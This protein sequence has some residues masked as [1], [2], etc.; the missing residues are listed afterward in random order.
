MGK[1]NPTPF[2]RREELLDDVC[3]CGETVNDIAIRASPI[4]ASLSRDL[5]SRLKN[6]SY[7]SAPSMSIRSTRITR[8]F[9]T[10]AT[11]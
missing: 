7:R 3:K 11:A 9:R 6:R 8:G 5:L 2:S 4:R 10:T 1:P